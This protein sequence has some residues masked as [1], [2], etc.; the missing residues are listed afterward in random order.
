MISARQI[1]AARALIGLS[2]EELA[3]KA[4]CGIA[5]V[6]RIEASVSAISGTAQ[7]ISKLEKALQSA[8]ITFVEGDGKMGPGVRLSKPTR[9]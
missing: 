2:Q 3:D 8:G 6:R 9:T 7:T 4:K 1:K 5:T